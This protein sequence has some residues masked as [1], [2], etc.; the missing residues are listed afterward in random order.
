MKT[1]KFDLCSMVFKIIQSKIPSECEKLSNLPRQQDLS[2]EKAGTSPSEI[3]IKIKAK[4][5]LSA[6]SYNFHWVNI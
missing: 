6:F 1:H 2:Y 5:K 4:M 3:S